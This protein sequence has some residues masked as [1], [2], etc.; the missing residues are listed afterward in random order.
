MKPSEVAE[1][2]NQLT[3]NGDWEVAAYTVTFRSSTGQTHTL[4][5]KE[6]VTANGT[7][8]KK[9][10]VEVDE[11][12]VAGL[13]QNPLYKYIDVD[14]QLQLA[15]QWCLENSRKLTRQFFTNWLGKAVVRKGTSSVLNQRYNQF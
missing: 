2:I 5:W 1:A 13:K 4:A 12:Y 14:L 7:T 15:N 9:R 3:K 11:V 8:Y 6:P 10:P